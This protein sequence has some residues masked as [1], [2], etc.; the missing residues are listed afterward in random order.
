[1]EALVASATIFLRKRF[2]ELI[3]ELAGEL[4]FEA[5]ITSGTGDLVMDAAGAVMR[6]FA[7]EVNARFVI[8]GAD[9]A[10]WIAQN[11][12]VVVD[13]DM[14]NELAV[15]AMRANRVRLVREFTEQQ[16]DLFTQILADAQ[17][18]GRNPRETAR[19]LKQ[20]LG[21]T[22]RQAEAVE[23]YRRALEMGSRDALQR[24]LRDRRYD[25]TV[26]AAIEG[27][28]TLTP[29]QIDRMVDRYRERYVAYRA[30]MIARTEALRAVHQGAEAMY[31]QA[32]EA[33]VLAPTD[34]VRTWLTAGDERVRGSHSFMH[35]QQRPVGE[36]FLSGDG[37][38]LMYPGDPDAPGSETI[39]CRCVLTT[40]FAQ[41]A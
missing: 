21:L 15:E 22:R 13:F 38:Y 8:A 39:H 12:N 24:A 14:V 31:Q 36:P 3:E 40:V 11:V 26:E 20:S 23:N 34:L 18:A 29:E 2:L 10:N 5:I 17:I 4:D 28:K 1:M 33:G 7:S 32:F 27:T 9:T 25:R 6:K 30:T 37:N 16:R 19:L 35:E 41:D